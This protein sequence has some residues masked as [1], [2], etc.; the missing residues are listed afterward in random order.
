M[1][2]SVT[3]AV[4]FLVLAQFSPA[5]FAKRA[6]ASKG[7]RAV[8]LL[9]ITANG[10]AHLIPVVFMDNGEFYDANAYKASP[11]PMALE[12]DTVYEGVRTGVSQG[13]FTV[14]GALHSGSAWIGTGKWQD[15]AALDAEKKKKATPETP[16][17]E[18]DKPPVLRRAKSEKPAPAPAPTTPQAPPVSA[19]PQAKPPAPA[20]SAAATTTDDAD[21]PMLHRGKPTPA[22]MTEE[23]ELAAFKAAADKGP[24]QV[25][26]A[27]SDA[28]G[29]D[30]RSYAFVMK[31]GEEETFRKKMLAMAS[32]EVRA[33]MKQLSSAMVGAAQKPAPRATQA[34]KLALVNLEDVQLRVFD[35]SSSNEPIL[36]LTAQVREAKPAGG[37]KAVAGPKSYVTLV[38]RDDIYNELHK[39]FSSVTDAQH[40][41]AL[42]RMELIDAVD[43][44]GD[45]RGELLFRETSD[46]G[47]AF[48]VYR[49]IGN[50]L[51]PLFQ[52]TPAK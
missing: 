31:P 40:L 17:E 28:G 43:A 45:G 6:K 9:E 41:D 13:L 18:T 35:L 48:S 22:P 1:R 19:A 26:P 27:I 39:V 4:V 47:S 25:I 49:V 24:V 52:G 10:K 21:R 36:V 16:K 38:A 8:G 34:S 51:W 3:L 2:R 42:P 15:T 33:R 14:A 23:Q 32:D 5:Q 50:Q 29:P 37:G 7:P 30:P 11:V 46:A 12:T 44:D 20:A